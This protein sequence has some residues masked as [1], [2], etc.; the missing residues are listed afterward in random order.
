[1]NALD[2]PCPGDSGDRLCFAPLWRAVQW[3]QSGQTSAAELV[4]ACEQAYLVANATVNAMV[5]V[6]F[7][8]AHRAAAESDQR[9]RA[10]AA[11]GALDGIPFSIKESFDVQGWPTSCGSPAHAA[12]YASQDALVVQRLRAQGAVLLGKTNVPLGLRDWQTYNALYGTTRNPRDPSR[13]PGGSSGGSAAAV[14]AGM[15]FFDIGSDIGS[16]LRNPAHYCGVFSHKSSLGIVPLTGH[17]TAAPGFAAQDINVAGPVARSAHDLEC[18]LQT[19]AGPEADEALAYHLTLP[20]CAHTALS[21]FRVAVLPSHPFA[22]VDAEVSETIE[23]V[24]RWLESQDTKVSWL[25][26]PDIDASELWLIYILLLRAT[27]S[28]YMDDAAFAALLD[29]A[30]PTSTDRSYAALQ[31]VGTGMHHRRWLH[32][33]AARRRFAQAWQRFF[34]D[35]DVL[36]CPVAATTAFPLNEAGEPWQRV[37][38]VNGNLQ[39][40]TTQLFWAG[41]SGLCGLPSTIAPIGPGRSGLPVGVQIVA[42]RFGDLTSLRFAQLLESSGYAFQPPLVETPTAQDANRR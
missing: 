7:E 14:C 28:I 35:Y 9:R 13:T 2:L 20:R 23:G 37:L 1:L 12:H 29:R 25:A 38:S 22:E 39:S 18:V 3:L 27:T 10:N 8:A 4:D 36:L 5:V 26:R 32:L 40:M 41:Y 30:E 24:G 15:S 33:Q 42:P 17:G 21:T 34:C 6:N 16:S 19:I 11:L 31:F